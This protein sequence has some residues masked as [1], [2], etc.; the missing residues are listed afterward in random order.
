MEQGFFAAERIAISSDGRDIYYSEI[1]SYYPNTGESI[2]K[3]SYTGGKW[4][5]PSTLFA[6][7]AAPALSATGDTMYLEAN[8][9]TLDFFVKMVSAWAKP[10]KDFMQCLIR[11]II[12]RLLGNGNY[13]I[14][15]KSGN[16]A[17]LSDWGRVKIN[18]I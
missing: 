5:G 4:V 14:S 9:E 16:G 10:E 3:Y 6:G 17:G 12:F 15:S 2:K 11:H 18:R 1:K 13:Y 8:F 7:Y